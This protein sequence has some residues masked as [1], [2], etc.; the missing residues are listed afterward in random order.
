MAIPI[1]IPGLGDIR[2]FFSVGKDWYQ[3]QKK[4]RLF[5]AW[6]KAKLSDMYSAVIEYYSDLGDSLLL[7]PQSKRGP[8]KMPLYVVSDSNTISDANFTK[9]F[10]SKMESVEP[11]KLQ[12]DFWNFYCELKKSTSYDSDIFRLVGFQR[13]EDGL[14]LNFEMGKFSHSVMCQYIFEHE[15]VTLLANDSKPKRKKFKLRNALASNV[16]MIH[17]FLREQIARIGICNLIILRAEKDI[18][19]PIVQKRAK[20]SMIQQHL[21][22]PV[23]SCIFEVAT[24]PKADFDLK[25]TVL[26]EVYE[27]LFGNPDVRNISKNLNPYF[28]YEK[29]GIAD[30]IDL[31]DA[32]TATFEITGF[33][34][35]LIR[36]VPEITTLLVVKD[37]SYY[38]K[39]Y[40]SSKSFKAPFSLNE[41]FKTCSPFQIPFDLDDVEEYLMN[42]IMTDPD[43][44]PNDRG[45]DPLMWTLP[46]GFSFYQ[47]LKRAT[48]TG[49]L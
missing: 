10:E 14:D 34:I 38:Q 11:S 21:F 15:L 8:L 24:T 35:D 39:H 4:K 20:L 25:H 41:E 42:H 47:G 43:G 23:S 33:C 22:D 37:E 49:L 27:E 46:G 9:H 6:E 5:N 13:K 16:E 30:L 1:P 17:S 45:F 26:R 44:N 3:K 32:G 29:D 28:F 12:K 36:I 48:A 31:I 2:D 18:Y 7:Y 19:I 40:A